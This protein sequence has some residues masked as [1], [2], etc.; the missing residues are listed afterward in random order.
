MDICFVDFETTGIDVFKDNPLEIG[1]VLTNEFGD[2]KK[3]FSTLIKPRT[4]R[5]SSASA[6]E[7]HG[8]TFDKL[9]NSPNQK[10]VLNLF[11]ETLGT[12]Y[13][14][15][16][17]NIN[18]DVTFFR[19]MCHIQKMMGLYNKIHYRHIDIQ[20]IVYYL[21]F[22][23]ILPESC[24]RLDDLIKFFNLSR[25]KNHNALEDAKITAEVFRKLIQLKNS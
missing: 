25:N 11:F 15:A 17:W 12:N 19:R 6:I 14:F 1:A 2:I 8:L 24:N 16:G 5:Q 23:Q 10:E 13:R 22:N 3:T 20:S 18:F 21:K 4:G 7:I 9:Q